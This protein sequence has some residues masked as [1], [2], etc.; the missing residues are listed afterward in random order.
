MRGAGKKNSTTY[1]EAAWLFHREM[2]IDGQVDFQGDHALPKLAP[3]FL[4]E[5][6]F[7]WD[8][9]PAETHRNLLATPDIRLGPRLN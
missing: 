6:G 2:V 5:E 4:A 7:V 1:V 8:E 9:S 3:Q